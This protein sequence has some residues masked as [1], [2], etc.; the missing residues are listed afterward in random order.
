MGPREER[1][2]KRDP[3]FREKALGGLNR[4]RYGRFWKLG[5]N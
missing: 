5:K 4:E 3:V 1:R 2:K